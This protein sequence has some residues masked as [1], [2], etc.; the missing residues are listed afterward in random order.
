MSF[1]GAVKLTGESEYKK[2]LKSITQSLKEVSSEMKLVTATYA[3][4]EKSADA[5]K[6]KT[7]V[8]TKKA[9]LQKQKVEELKKAY[10][11]LKQQYDENTKKNTELSAKYDA[12]K[13]KLDELGKTVGKSSEEYKKQAEV[14]A[15]LAKEVK[16]STDAQEANEKTLS[17]MRIE[18]N[19]TETELKNTENAMNGVESATQKAEGGFTVFKGALA[20]IIANTVQNAISKMKELAESTIAVGMGFEASMSKV[21]AISGASAEEMEV[22][23]NTAKEYGKT[24]KF[25]ASESADALSYMAL[26]GWD[27]TQSADALGGVLDL[28]S[29]SGMDLAQASDM[30]T[31]YLTAF[32][33]SAEESGYFADVL[34]YAQSNANTST[35]QLGEA[36]Q[37]CASVLA[38]SGQTMETTTALLAKMSDSSLKGSRAGTALSAIMRDINKNMGSA[39]FTTKGFTKASNDLGYSTAGL[40]SALNDAG[41]SSKDLNTALQDSHGD[42][43]AFMSELQGLA[44][45]GV[46]VSGVM[47]SVGWDAEGVGEIF[48]KITDDSKQFTIAIGEN[49]V[50]VTDAEGNYRSLTDI[51]KDVEDATDGMSEAERSNALQSTFTAD[52]IKGVT[53]LL[54]SG[55]GDVQDFEEAL[56]GSTGTAKEMS[57]VMQDNLAGD[58]TNLKS[59]FEGVQIELYEKLEPALRGVVDFLSKLTSALGFVVENA[60]AVTAGLKILGGAM[61]TY[62]A[63]TTAVKIM[64]DGWK[65]LTIV[66]KAQTIAQQALNLVMSA[67]PIGLVISAITALV[68][69]FIYF[70]KTS[71]GFRNFFSGMWEGFKEVVTAFVGVITEGFGAI[72]ELLQMFGDFIVEGAVNLWDTVVETFSGVVEWIDETIIQPVIEAFNAV[73]EFFAT[74][75]TSIAQFGADCWNGIVAVWDVVSSWFNDNIITPVH[76]FF[77]NFFDN[78]LNGFKVLWDGIV[79]VWTVVSSWFNDNIITPVREFFVGMWENVTGG[80]RKAWEG[81]KSVFSVVSSWFEN[82]FSKAWNAVKK[83]FSTGGK[84]FDGIKE[85]IVTAFKAVVNAI[86]GGI[87]KVIAIPFKAINGILSKIRNISIAGVTPFSGI[88]HTLDIPEIP[89]LARGGIVNGATTFIAGEAGKEAVIPLENN[90]GW[91]TNLAERLAVSLERPLSRVATGAVETRNAE[92]YNYE[93]LVDGFKSA[94]SQMA[95]TLDDDKLGAFVD[96]TVTN[97]IYY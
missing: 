48:Q 56:K 24:T 18:L 6:A 86:I 55:V 92:V 43:N 72:W 52:S 81:I 87:N 77:A 8:L 90:T 45:E 68:G 94:L 53:T 75:F 21:Q 27:A 11:T 54:N 10:K 80:A 84:I 36:Y 93:K 22:L 70:W 28:A 57:D 40:T 5:L 19:K 76:D 49:D 46:D 16:K 9:D 12:E 65:A 82:V 78:L 50:A 32:G 59:K 25:S 71:E 64:T 83:V 47:E 39:E 95:V 17:N 88:V 91:I 3:G 62:L 26:A 13:K 63:Y 79:A 41:I 38:S 30:V 29:A 97:A 4:N 69:L 96:K 2:A 58:V 34:A 31:D 89:K 14:V 44:K 42:V 61:A 1:G 35:V 20:D 23:K 51:L 7:E 60:D 85:G 15:D 74:V 73:V 67:N 33:M 66:T 37:N